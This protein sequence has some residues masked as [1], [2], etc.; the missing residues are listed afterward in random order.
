MI[1]SSVTDTGWLDEVPAD[2][3]TLV[4]AEGLLMYLTES[5][6]R[7]LLRRL[8]DRFS[9]GELLFDTLSAIGPRLSKVFTKGIV[10]WGAGDVRELEQWNPRLRFIEQTSSLDGYEAIP[11]VPQ[12]LLYR[13]MYA[14]PA[15]AY[16][17]VNRFAF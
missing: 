2:R 7:D 17:V 8:T 4:V 16:D 12:R 13:A 3:P 11:D 5:E 6:V 15:R 14:T 1:A 9:S 10:K